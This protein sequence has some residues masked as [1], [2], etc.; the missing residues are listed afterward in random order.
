MELGQFEQLRCGYST[1]YGGSCNNY[2][3]S[4]LNYIL[5]GQA[6]FWT[7]STML[8]YFDNQAEILCRSVR[9]CNKNTTHL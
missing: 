5:E 6:T 9:G 7:W 2:G 4:L 1:K 8:S 3:K